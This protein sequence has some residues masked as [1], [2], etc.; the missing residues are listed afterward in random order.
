MLDNKWNNHINTL[1]N[2][3]MRKF[4]YVFNEVRDIFNP[5][6]KNVINVSLVQLIIYYEIF[7]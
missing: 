4:F 7:M 1:T 3:N 6:T 5:Q 2:N